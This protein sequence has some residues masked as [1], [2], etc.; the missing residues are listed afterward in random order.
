MQS[1]NGSKPKVIVVAD[2]GCLK[3]Y[4]LE[5]T[6]LGTPHLTLICEEVVREAVE[7]ISDHVSDFAGR[8]S[9]SGLPGRSAP[10]SDDHNLRLELEHRAIKHLASRIKTISESGGDAAPICLIAHK[11]IL[12]GLMSELPGSMRNRVQFTLARDLVKAEAR[13]LIDVLV[14]EGVITAVPVD[15]KPVH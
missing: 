1:T 2:L 13:H 14:Q 11:E 10:M 5:R 12:K 8:H 6:P 4:R 9:S 3:A 15:K 7:R